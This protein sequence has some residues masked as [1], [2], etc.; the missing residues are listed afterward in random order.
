MS[1]TA[2]DLA[3][4]RAAIASGASQVRFSDGRM[5]MFRSQGDL[6]AL[7]KK[8]EAA[9]NPAANVDRRVDVPTYDRW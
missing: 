7:E 5:T 4:V 3:Q 9:L 2:D 1:Y 6:I 8:I